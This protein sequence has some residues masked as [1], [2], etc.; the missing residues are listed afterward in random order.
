MQG[1]AVVIDA[2]TLRVGRWPV[3]L[4]GYD[5]PP[6]GLACQDHERYDCGREA[7]DRLK[8]FAQGRQVRCEVKRRGTVKVGRCEAL[9]VE[10]YNAHRVDRWSDLAF[11]LIQGG[12]GVERASESRGHYA[13]A[14]DT[15]QAGKAGVWASTTWRGD[16]RRR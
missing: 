2:E 13:E 12:S 16:H 10:M 6:L 7:A 15:A 3:R 1:T 11:D 8:Y 5:A 9:R 14:A 4:W